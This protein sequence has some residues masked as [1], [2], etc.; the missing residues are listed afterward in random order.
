MY[1]MRKL[2]LILFFIFALTEINLG[3]ENDKNNINVDIE[4][5]SPKTTQIIHVLLNRDDVYEFC[6]NFY[7][8]YYTTTSDTI[9]NEYY[10]VEKDMI[11]DSIVEYNA[12]KI[13]SIEL[14]MKLLS[15]E[16]KEKVFIVPLY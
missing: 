11:N 15:D 14:K 12:M 9:N 8:F 5:K 10:I 3:Q 2:F 16:I 13:N 7:N 1:S 6:D 4:F